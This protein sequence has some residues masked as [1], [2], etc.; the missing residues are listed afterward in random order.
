MQVKKFWAGL[1]SVMLIVSCLAG[2]SGNGDDSGKDDS[3][4]AVSQQ[5]SSKPGNSQEDSWSGRRVRDAFY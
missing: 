1:L 3:S 5:E 2:C 4:K